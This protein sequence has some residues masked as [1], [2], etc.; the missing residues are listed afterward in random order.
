MTAGGLA[1]GTDKSKRAFIS[2]SSTS[3]TPRLIPH[4]RWPGGVSMQPRP[5]SPQSPSL[6]RAPAAV[7]R[8][9]RPGERRPQPGDP[10]A[11]WGRWDGAASAGVERGGG[12]AAAAAGDAQRQGR[13]D[14]RL[15][16]FMGRKP[17]VVFRRSGGTAGVSC[18]LAPDSREGGGDCDEP[19][20]RRGE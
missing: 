8:R 5:P 12:A 7:R 4:Q 1:E 6:R 20:V 17:G 18:A 3:S 16:W 11:P 13:H 19:R 14:Q 15:G 9:C 10:K 2:R